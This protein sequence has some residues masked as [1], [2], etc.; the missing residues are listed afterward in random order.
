MFFKRY[1]LSILEEAF[2]TRTT[3]LSIPIFIVLWEGYM[4]SIYLYC[5]INVLSKWD[6]SLFN[7]T[8]FQ[9]KPHSSPAMLNESLLS[10][11]YWGTFGSMYVSGKLATYPSP[12]LTL[13]LSS[14][15]G[16]ILGLGRGRLAVSPDTFSL[17]LFYP[18][19]EEAFTTRVTQLSTPFWDRL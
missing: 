1:F 11:G 5:V 4:K 12:N 6:Q 2:A 16:Q 3:S 10:P 7:F 14:R 19:P 18:R 8:K 15:F 9:K 17:S 13:T